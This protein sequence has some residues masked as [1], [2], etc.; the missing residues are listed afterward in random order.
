MTKKKDPRCCGTCI[1][2]KDSVMHPDQIRCFVGG[3]ITGPFRRD[4]DACLMYRQ[5]TSKPADTP[6]RPGKNGSTK[7]GSAKRVEF[8]WT[9]ELDDKLRHYYSFTQKSVPEISKIIG[10]DTRLIHLR[11]RKLSLLRRRDSKVNA[12]PPVTIDPSKDKYPGIRCCKGQCCKHKFSC[13]HYYHWIE[14]GKPVHNLINS[15]SSCINVSYSHHNESAS[16]ATGS[17]H[18]YIG[19][20]GSRTPDIYYRDSPNDQQ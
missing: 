11:I 6:S 5:K 16:L 18:E 1:F 8:Q 19:L 17:F 3:T 10:V 7:Q 20:D 13:R 14:R 2:S 12:A 4:T 9:S 15:V